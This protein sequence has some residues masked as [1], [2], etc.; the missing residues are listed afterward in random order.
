M[1]AEVETWGHD[2]DRA[3]VESRY[4]DTFAGAFCAPVKFDSDSDTDDDHVDEY[5]WGV[6]APQPL[7]VVSTC[8]ADWHGMRFAGQVEAGTP[9]TEI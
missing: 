5:E 1:G 6:N 8:S 2:F 4:L 7:R 9:C 3:R